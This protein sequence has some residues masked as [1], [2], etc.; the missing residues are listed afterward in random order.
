MLLHS[1]EVSVRG[2]DF[3]LL[4]CVIARLE[5]RSVDAT[6][7]VHS[8]IFAVLTLGDPQRQGSVPVHTNGFSLSEV[9]DCNALYKR[10]REEHACGRYEQGFLEFLL[11][12]LRP[13]SQF[14]L[15]FLVQ[16]SR[17]H[18]FSLR[19]DRQVQLFGR[20]PLDAD[21]LPVYFEAVLVPS[22]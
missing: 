2:G 10:W 16:N 20:F 6:P 4:D 11:R 19:L 15:E 12:F 8:T 13:R 17:M 5:L 3:R 18:G 7:S 21:V 1:S 14:H 22:D 9:S